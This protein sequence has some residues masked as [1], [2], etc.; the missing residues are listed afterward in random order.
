MTPQQAEKIA[1]EF[2]CRASKSGDMM[3]ND[4]SGKNIGETCKTYLKE[5]LN[6]RLYGRCKTFTSKYTEKGLQTE[7]DGI[8]LIAVNRNKFYKKNTER[9]ENEWIIGECDIYSKD[10]SLVIDN[11]SSYELS[12]FPMWET[13]LKSKEN[14]TQVKCYAGLWNAENALVCFTLNNMKAEQLDPQLEQFDYYARKNN[15]RK[16]IDSSATD[17][18]LATFVNGRIFTKDKFDVYNSA[19]F[20][21]LKGYNFIEIPETK[22]YKEFSVEIK[23]DEIE[24]IYTRVEACRK[25][26]KDMLLDNRSKTSC[27]THKQ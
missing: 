12:T 4:R 19:F 10:E 3:T 11:K 5:W 6:E 13:D 25:I 21:D 18:E 14:I 7:E 15:E 22:R 1:N 20:P 23:Q 16:G 8:T 26:L 24:S 17:L 27:G 9:K 2:K